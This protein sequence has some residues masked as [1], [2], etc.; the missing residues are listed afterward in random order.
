MRET[1][2]RL[3]EAG[4]VPSKR[5]PAWGLALLWREDP[6]V[7]WLQ[8]EWDEE[9]RFAGSGFSLFYPQKAYSY[10]THHEDPLPISIRKWL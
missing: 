1:W 2:E 8:G 5:L 10:Y 9:E 7:T 3:C 4:D 6:S